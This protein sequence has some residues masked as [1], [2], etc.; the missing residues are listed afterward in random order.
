MKANEQLKKWVRSV[1]LWLASYKAQEVLYFKSDNG[2]YIY[3]LVLGE[4]CQNDEQFYKIFPDAHPIPEYIF[5][6]MNEQ[7]ITMVLVGDEKD[8]D[9][10]E[11]EFEDVVSQPLR[12]VN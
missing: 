2:K 10:L 12:A 5:E 1:A 11:P 8:V 3:F 9:R 6:R 4:H 7:G